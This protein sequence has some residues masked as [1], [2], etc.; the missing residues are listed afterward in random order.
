M[1]K[2]ILSTLSIF[3]IGSIIFIS[4]KP[5]NNDDAITPTY[6]DEASSGTGG[7]PNITNVT[8]T[9]TIATTSTQQN[10]TLSGIGTVGV[11]SNINCSTPAPLCLVTSNSS[12]GTSISICFSTAPTAGTYQFVSSQGLLGPGKAFMAITSPPGQDVGSVWNSDAGSV[13]VTV[14]GTGIKATFSNIQCK[15]TPGS[16]YAVTASGEV[17]CL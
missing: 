1:K 10:T 12:L 17:G 13:V 4:C 15:K 8:T 11:W 3:V 16:F 9:G 14:S 2:I 6:K 5:K 7:N